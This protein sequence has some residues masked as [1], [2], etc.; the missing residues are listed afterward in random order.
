MIWRRPDKYWA[1]T[2]Y[3]EFKLTII[4]LWLTWWWHKVVRCCLSNIQYPVLSGIF[5]NSGRSYSWILFD[6]SVFCIASRNE[7]PSLKLIHIVSATNVAKIVPPNCANSSI[8]QLLPCC[9]KQMHLLVQGYIQNSR[10]AIWHGMS[11]WLRAEL[12][13]HLSLCIPY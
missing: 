8:E 11:L 3:P 13:N 6:P 9:K 10:C 1:F 4:T 12:C 2:G 7:C 5:S